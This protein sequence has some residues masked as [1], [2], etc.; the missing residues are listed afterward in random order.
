MRTVHFYLVSSIAIAAM[1]GGCAKPPMPYKAAVSVT[2]PTGR[3]AADLSIT[4]FDSSGSH[5]E[6]FVDSKSTLESVVASMPEGRYAA[7]SIHFGGYAREVTEVSLFERKKLATSARSATL[8]EGTSPLFAV[9]EQDLK[10]VLSGVS[11]RAVVVII[12]DGRVTD[13]AGRSGA[14]ERTLAAGREVVALHSGP[15]CFHTIQSGNSSE[16]AAMLEA[17]S[18]LTSCGSHRNASTLAT[19]PALQQFSR[20]VYLAAGPA[21][22]AKSPAPLKDTDGDGVFDPRDACPH[23]PSSA[24]VDARG[25]WTISG[26]QFSVNASTIE[27]GA[28]KSL[29]EDVQVLKDHPKLRVRVDGH[30]DADGSAAYNQQLSERRAASVRD[31]LVSNGIPADR[32]A[33][34][35]LGESKPIAPNDSTEHKRLNRR[36]ELTI[37][38]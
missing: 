4:I 23:T 7:G 20:D 38:D 11:G 35:G 19:A 36:V 2:P 8:L 13:F 31:Y 15:V 33:V 10:P 22:Q 30:T 5:E 37:L 24:H 16:G 9:F 18:R 21:P 27:S 28:E 34:Q 3:V 6:L 32:L 29:A 14:E 25:C 17:I 12:S 1:L 26:L